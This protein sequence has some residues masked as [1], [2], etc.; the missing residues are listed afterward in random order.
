MY[1]CQLL[2]KKKEIND[3]LFRI[4]EKAG[5][6]YEDILFYSANHTLVDEIV[7]LNIMSMVVP[8]KK[9]LKRGVLDTGLGYYKAQN[10]SLG[11]ADYS[12]PDK[13]SEFPDATI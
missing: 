9:G 8:E 1:L 2:H 7:K 4:K 11:S 12:Y 10:V 13:D 5:C 6:T 3:F